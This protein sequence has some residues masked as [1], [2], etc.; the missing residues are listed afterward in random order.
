[1]S[2]E[3]GEVGS[4]P[5]VRIPCNSFS[6]KKGKKQSI[7][8]IYLFIPRQ[9]LTPTIWNSIPLGSGEIKGNQLVVG[10]NPAFCIILHLK[11]I[12]ICTSSATLHYGPHFCGQ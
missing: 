8:K 5:G 3:A 9:F 10:S 7:Q 6:P 11:C 4:I 2:L 12:L 1:M